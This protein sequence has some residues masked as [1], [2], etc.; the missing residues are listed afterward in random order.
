MTVRGAAQSIK[1]LVTGKQWKH[2]KQKSIIVKFSFLSRTVSQVHRRFEPMRSS[3]DSKNSLGI[4]DSSLDEVYNN[5]TIIQV[6]NY[7]GSVAAASNDVLLNFTV[8][9]LKVLHR[10]NRR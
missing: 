7:E 5:G 8:P 3:D 9:I 1:L 6:W 10:G 4:Y 2:K